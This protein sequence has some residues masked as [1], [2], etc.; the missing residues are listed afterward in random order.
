MWITNFRLSSGTYLNLVRNSRLSKH[1]KT[2]WTYTSNL[3]RFI[4]SKVNSSTFLAPLLDICDK[5]IHFLLINS[6]MF[7]NLSPL[8]YSHSHNHPHSFIS[9]SLCLLVSA[10][11]PLDTAYKSY[12]A[13][14]TLHE[15]CWKNKHTH[16]SVKKT[17]T[18]V[19]K[20][21]NNSIKKLL[22]KS[23]LVAKFEFTHIPPKY[24]IF[25]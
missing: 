6:I 13:G 20:N 19:L 8:T 2:N 21:L 23:S 15:Q 4:V 5:S 18:W 17:W 14:W 22:I 24:L 11:C 10:Y 9:S 1:P 7:F 16:T 12:W 3:A 25:Q